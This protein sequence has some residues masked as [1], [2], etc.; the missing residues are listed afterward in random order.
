MANNLN[1]VTRALHR[2]FIAVI[3]GI[4]TCVGSL[5]RPAQAE[6]INVLILGDSVAS[7]LRWSPPSMKALWKQ[8]FSVTLEV[9]GCQK[10]VDPG[11]L[12][13]DV[14]Q[15]SALQLIRKHRD[16]K[17]D[18]VVVATGYN[19]TGAAYLQKSIRRIHSEVSQQGARL[20]WLTYRENGNVRIKARTFNKVVKSQAKS[21]KFFVLDWE[22]I[23]RKQKHWFTGDGVHMNAHGGVRLGNHIRRALDAIVAGTPISTTTTTPTTT[24]VVANG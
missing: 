21:L 5:A 11:C 1:K 13:G 18:I 17:F 16:K 10:L 15:P 24:S 19:D 22:Q 4:T 14:A 7:V 6:Q 20:L 23:A 8:P 12:E 2:L 3:I 9:W